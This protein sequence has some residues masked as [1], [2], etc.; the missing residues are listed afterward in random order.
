MRRNPERRSLRAKRDAVLVLDLQRVWHANWQAYGADAVWLQTNR[1]GIRVA[2]CAVERQMG[3][4]GFQSAR[5]VKSVRT[6][7]PDTSAPR[8]LDRV[9]RHLQSRQAKPAVGIRLHL[10]KHMAGLAR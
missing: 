9:N 7:T 3:G 4:L 10:R 1:E 2:R 8:P 6:T 5:R